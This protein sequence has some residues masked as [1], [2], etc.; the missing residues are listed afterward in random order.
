MKTAVAASILG[1]LLLPAALQAAFDD[2]A[3]AQARRLADAGDH[4]GAV[5]LLED[6]LT[7]ANAGD[8]PAIV[9]LLKRSYKALADE[10]ESRGN[11]R[12]AVRQRDNLSILEEATSGGRSRAAAV[13]AGGAA[14]GQRAGVAGES[15]PAA[16]RPAGV[17]SP[18]PAEVPRESVAGLGLQAAPA[19]PRTDGSP[20]PV[21]PSEAPSRIAPGGRFPAFSVPPAMPVPAEL[22][23]PARLGPPRGALSS[24]P[25]AVPEP[26]ASRPAPT[27]RVDPRLTEADR[28]FRARQYVEAGDLYSALAGEDRLPAARREQWVYCRWA[29]I[30]AKINARPRTSAEWDAIEAEIAETQKQNPGKWFGEYLH[31]KVSELRPPRKGGD[32]LVVRGADPDESKP[33]RLKRLFGRGEGRADVQPKITPAPQV[34]KSEGAWQIQESENFRIYHQNGVLAAHMA[35]EAERVRARQAGTWLGNASDRP[36]SPKCEI[37]LHA[38]GQSLAQATGQ[39]EQSPGFSTMASDGTKVVT[40]KMNLRAD[41]P[42]L[43][44]SILPHEVTHVVLADLFT[45][46]Q[47]PRWADEG[48]AVMAEPAPE[49]AGRAAEF[50]EPLQNGRA[51]KLKSLMSMD[52]PDPRDWNLYYA[53]SVLLTRFLIEQGKPDQ[54]I[55]FAKRAQS[56]NIEPALREIYQIDG[57]ADLEARFGDYA[58]RQLGVQTAEAIDVENLP[59]RR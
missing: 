16:S 52:Y 30:V 25:A 44:V 49:R 3:I 57:F 18:R 21:T 6:A 13:S 42:D 7:E 53:E 59:V 51:F 14:Q 58:R 47:I 15:R 32:R 31:N 26:A 8:Q 33:G 36:W 20:M 56:D 50:K 48:L 35:D 4:A 11:K 27:P 19:V 43:L 40:R 10:A 38:D 28:L 39:P 17:K 5:Q 46:Q 22:P 2:G 24:G 41:H 54:F 12:E 37:Y 9:N 34:S 29:K 1:A 45:A 23:P 55:A